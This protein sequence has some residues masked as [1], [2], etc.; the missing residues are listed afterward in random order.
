MKKVTA[1]W[2]NFI[3]SQLTWGPCTSREQTAGHAE[4]HWGKVCADLQHMASDLPGSSQ[5]SLPMTWTEETRVSLSFACIHRS[6]QF[7]TEREKLDCCAFNRCLHKHPWIVWFVYLSKV[8][9]QVAPLDYSTSNLPMSHQSLCCWPGYRL[10]QLS[11]MV[12][13][14]RRDPSQ[15]DWAPQGTEGKKLFF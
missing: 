3:S 11:V 2:V 6:K 14:S 7:P 1:F 10:Q 9:C 4:Q 15:P 5:S 8:K 13:T 12:G